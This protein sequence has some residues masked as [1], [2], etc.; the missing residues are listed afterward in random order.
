[1]CATSTRALPARAASSSFSASASV[2][3]NG[4]S[5]R[6]A[7]SGQEVREGELRRGTRAGWRLTP[8]QRRD[9][10]FSDTRGGCGVQTLGHPCGSVERRVDARTDGQETFG[11]KAVENEG[12]FLRHHFAAADDVIT[13]H[14]N[15][16]PRHQ[17]RTPPKR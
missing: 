1:M 2:G 5:M 10:S 15:T 4:F 13:Q 3:A 6:N 11:P 8:H 12:V 17:Q 14:A 9:P 16:V 7:P